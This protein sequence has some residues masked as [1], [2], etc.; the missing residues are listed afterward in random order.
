ADSMSPAGPLQIIHVTTASSGSA[1][2]RSQ[3]KIGD[4]A[5]ITL[6]ENFIAAAGATAYQ[7][8]DALLLTV[9]HGAELTQVRLMADS[10]DAA[11]ITSAVLAVGAKAKL[12]LF[13]M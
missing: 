10:A 8:H 9:G 4:G 5:R 11:N 12:N 3:V 13:N 2:T 6:V 7:A 1:F